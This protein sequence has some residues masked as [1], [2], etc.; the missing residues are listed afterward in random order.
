LSENV[1][2][3]TGHD[4]VA[5]IVAACQFAIR[6]G[7]LHDRAMRIV[8][9]GVSFEQEILACYERENSGWPGFA[10][11]LDYLRAANTRCRGRWSFVLLSATDIASVKLPLHN[12]P[13]EVIPQSGLSVSAAVERLRQLPKHQMPECWERISAQKK[14]DFSQ[15]H[16]CLESESGILKHV[17]G[18]HRLLAYAL[19]EK[20]QEV[21]A[22]L[23]GL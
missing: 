11:G 1:T 2:T 7:L 20:D 21:P 4:S 14:R 9:E 22:F 16:I 23:A 13:I 8:K 6:V 3:T 12:H 18:V 17:D 10:V 15:M 19:F 5:G